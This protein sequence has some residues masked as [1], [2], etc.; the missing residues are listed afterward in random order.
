[1]LAYMN[2]VAEIGIYY[3]STPK[4]KPVIK[5]GNDAFKLLIDNWDENL[6]ELQEEFKV[7]LLNNAN[8]VLGILPLSKGGITS[9]L[10]DWKKRSN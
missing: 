6:I 4:V 3:K 7:I 9:C 8:K 5:S 10:V 1:M 2:Q